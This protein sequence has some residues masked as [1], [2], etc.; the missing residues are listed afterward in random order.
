M[1][2]G[3]T[4]PGTPRR[5]IAGTVAMLLLVSLPLSPTFA[6]VLPEAVM[7]DLDGRFDAFI[8]TDGFAEVDAD[9]LIGDDWYTPARFPDLTGSAMS[10]DSDI[11]P[12]TRT[13]LL[14]E[15]TEAGLSRV[16][17]RVTYRLEAASPDYAEIQHAY[18]E[19]TRFN[20]G[21]AIR[22]ELLASYGAEHAAPESVFGVG[23]HVS[24]R[25]VTGSLMGMRANV[26]RA[27]RKMVSDAEA[28]A[29][30]CLGIPCS[31]L[32]AVEGPEGKWQQMAPPSDSPAAYRHLEE[33]VANPA[34]IADYLFAYAT[35]DG[36]EPAE[37]TSDAPQ[38]IFVISMNVVGQEQT[39]FGLLH[40]TRLMDDAVSDIWTRR[41][42]V[43]GDLIEWRELTVHRPG[44]Q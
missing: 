43:G 16:R 31:S 7:S 23:P 36:E 28:G 3:Q 30:D 4:A 14:L 42:Q 20:L 18:I 34:R 6:V 5:A 32:V 44:R 11:D 8:Q 21:P 19:V 24:W 10:P 39:A 26:I 17:Y 37:G 35:R 13:M 22:E 9:T 41:I 33:A 40:Q 2:G 1:P 25:F 38:M 27:S 15:S 12:V 29:T